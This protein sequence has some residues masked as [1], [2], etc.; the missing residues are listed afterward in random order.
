[1][2]YSKA[3]VRQRRS[4]GSVRDVTDMGR[5]SILGEND[6]SWDERVWMGVAVREHTLRTA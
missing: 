4:V 6:K 3:R 5:V 2:K 1:M